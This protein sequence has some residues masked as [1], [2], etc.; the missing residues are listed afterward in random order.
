MNTDFEFKEDPAALKSAR[1]KKAT[2]PEV[3]EEAPAVEEKVTVLEGGSPEYDPL[4]L[5]AVF[6]AL[7]F[8]GS[9]TED[10]KIGGKMKVTFQ[11]RSGKDVRAIMN[12]LDKAGFNLGLTV[13]SVRSLYNLA[14]STVNVNSRDL[15]GETLE[16]RID[17]IEEM[18]TAVISALMIALT[19]FDRKVEAAVHHG[20]EN[21]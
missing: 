13:E 15:S 20:E 18:P 4:E 14:Q 7:M 5:E 12:V 1:G 11:T 21:F 10:V 2:K 9:Y 17:L 3:I 8:E 16:R 19:K 6:D